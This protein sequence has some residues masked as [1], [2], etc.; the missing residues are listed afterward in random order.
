MNTQPSITSKTNHPTGEKSGPNQWNP[1]EQ[2]SWQPSPWRQ[3]LALG[4]ALLLVIAVGAYLRWAN[5]LLPREGTVAQ[6]DAGTLQTRRA[7]GIWEPLHAGDAVLPGQLLRSSPGTVALIRFFDGSQ[8]RVESA[9]EWQVDQ[10][11]GSHSSRIS[12]VTI[13]QLAGR[14]SLVSAPL[15]RGTSAQLRLELPGGTMR[16]VGAATLTTDEQ[17]STTCTQLQGQGQ[18][19]AGENRITLSPEEALR[20]SANG[21]LSAPLDE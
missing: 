21:E 18:V 5:R 2:G 13:H 14:A 9:G 19:R 15:L 1:L 17:G 7:E 6:L 16:L 3:G 10:L 12:R 20:L 8:M 11:E 4:L